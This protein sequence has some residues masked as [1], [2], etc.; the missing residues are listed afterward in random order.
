MLKH[1]EMPL[2]KRVWHFSRAIIDYSK[3]TNTSLMSFY[4]Y[5]IIQIPVFILMV[6]SIRKISHENEELTGAGAL[7]F[8]DL[9]EPD[10]YM[11]LPVAATALN[12]F[13]LGVSFLC[14]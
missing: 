10:P 3:Q 7:W 12:Y 11:I 4:F 9:N 1:S 8:K 6:L 2:Y 14:E 13:N 5:N